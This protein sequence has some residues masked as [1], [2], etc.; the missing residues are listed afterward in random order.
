[1][2]TEHSENKICPHPDCKCKGQEQPITNFSISNDDPAGWCKDCGKTAQKKKREFNKN[3]LNK[4]PPKDGMKRCSYHKVM[5]NISEFNTDVTSTDGYQCKCKE[6]QKIDRD[7]KAAKHADVS[8]TQ[9]KTCNDPKCENPHKP[10]SEF[11]KSNTGTLGH[12]NTCKVCRARKRREQNTHTPQTEGTKTCYGVL[13]I[14]DDGSGTEKGVSMFSTDQY[15]LDG[16]QNQCKNCKL[17]ATKKHVSTLDGFF[18]KLYCDI[19]QNA[20]KRAKTIEVKISKQ[21]IKDLYAKQQGKC[22]LT[23]MSLTHNAYNT[24]EREHHIINYFNISVDRIDSSKHYEKGNIQLVGAIVNRMKTDMKQE[25]F[26][27]LINMLHCHNFDTINKILLNKDDV[28]L[29]SK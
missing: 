9:M 8:E 13:C 20:K 3:N 24:K 2:P 6:A 29:Q 5:H 10:L 12:A 25:Q 26:L 18:T 4:E 22:A 16:L 27:E 17:E 1:M 21:D 7:K 11:N 23:G 28:K 15:N 14:Q 19:I